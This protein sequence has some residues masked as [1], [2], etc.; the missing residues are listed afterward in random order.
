V[1][2]LQLYSYEACPYAQR[3]QMAL[4]EKQ[5][6]YE[7]VEVD[8]YDRPS[9]WAELSPYG[10]VPLLKQGDAVVYESAIINEYLEDSFA[11]TPLLPADPLGRARARIWMA[12]CDSHFMPACHQLI[13]DRR[14]DHQQVENR[15][16]LCDVFLFM[17]KGMTELADGPYWMG[18][19]FT[20]VDAQFAP[21][22]ERF[23]CYEALW[24][25]EWPEQC[26]RLRSWFDQIRVRDSHIQTRH[27]DDFHM[28]RY[29]KY[30]QAS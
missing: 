22:F 7:L 20:L 30:D 19:Q 1:S 9:W 5:L 15:Q 13:E 10:K 25:A 24:Q 11:D 3:T 16:K 4:Q 28:Q 26:H 14:D 12:Y 18:E 21:F 6:D 2:E 29:R 23:G 8:L 27:D 17:E